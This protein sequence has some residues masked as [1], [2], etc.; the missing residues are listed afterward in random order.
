MRN[1]FV[2]PTIARTFLRPDGASVPDDEFFPYLRLPNGTFKT[3]RANRLPDVDA[4]LIALLK[5]E[6]RHYDLLDVAASSGTCTV[7]L[8]A[9]LTSQGIE[10]VMHA[11]DLILHASCLSLLLGRILFC[12]KD[13]ILQVDFAGLTFPNTPPSKLSGLLFFVARGLIGLSRRVGWSATP[14]PLLSLAARRSSVN[15]SEGDVFGEVYRAD[16][17][18]RFDVIRAANIL[19]ASYFTE[20]EVKRAIAN[21]KGRLR[22]EGLLVLVRTENEIN[23]TSIYR[24][25]NDSLEL[26]EHINGGVEI[27]P[28]IAETSN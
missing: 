14:V 8:D 17:A 22:S 4:R 26:V 27:A 28:C 5:R 12:E 13:H 16:P 19:T 11:S 20:A 24:L 21:L 18:L 1:P 9:A 3:T 2:A 10:H 25:H 6:A 23:L 7:E 15:F